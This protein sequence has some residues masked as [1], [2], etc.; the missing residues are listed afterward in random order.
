M[1]R[2]CDGSRP[3]S[4]PNFL[5]SSSS[6]SVPRSWRVAGGFRFHVATMVC[7]LVP[8]RALARRRLSPGRR[9]IIARRAL[10]IFN[11]AGSAAVHLESLK[12]SRITRN[13]EGGDVMERRHFLKFAVGFAAGAAALAA[14][15]QAAPL[16][17]AP[18][19]KD[20]Q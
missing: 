11:V 18:T 1:Q 8:G 19:A 6:C 12:L 17:P 4:M 3:S 15:A 14:G 2:N 5:P 10:Q 7:V 9:E 20:G 13:D 16:A